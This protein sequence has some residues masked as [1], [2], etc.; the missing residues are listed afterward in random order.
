MR[1]KICGMMPVRNEEHEL[2]LTARVALKWCDELVVLLHECSDRSAEIVREIANETG[3]VL[4][5]HVLGDWRE[6]EHRQQLLEDARGLGATHLAIIDADEV[7]TA[8][9]VPLMREIIESTPR[10]LILQL[11]LYNLRGAIDR[12]HANGI[13]GNRIVSVAFADNP[14]LHWGGD[15]FHQR[16]P[17][18]RRLAGYT[19]LRHSDG[20][21]MHLWASSLDRLRAKH[22]LYRV[23]ERVR[24]PQKQTSQIE[25]MYSWA[26]HGDPNNL[27]YGTPQT[28]TYADV[29]EQWWSG[30]ENLMTHLDLN[31]KPWQDAECDRIIDQHGREYFKG[32]R[33]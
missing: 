33:I 20:G 23:V 27:G 5:S 19:P 10:N 31:A 7:L 21:V 16:E 24:W 17:I 2:G 14:V 1:M 22:R 26:E 30:Y 18:G 15:T 6:M 11:P 9:L 13:W 3:R 25:K 28:W 12:Y 8:N 29:P 32:L 4:S